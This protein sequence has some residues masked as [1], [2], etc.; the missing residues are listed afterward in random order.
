MKRHKLRGAQTA[1]RWKSSHTHWSMRW[2]INTLIP[3][4]H[5]MKKEVLSI[6][7]AVQSIVK[8]EDVKEIQGMLNSTSVLNQVWPEDMEEILYLD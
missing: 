7:C 1:V 5:R 6:R 2:F 8:E 3:P 4:R